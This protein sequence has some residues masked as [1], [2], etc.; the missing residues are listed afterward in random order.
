M[1][2]KARVTPTVEVAQSPFG[3]SPYVGHMAMRFGRGLRCVRCFCK[4]TDD[5]R[6]EE[7][8]CLD[9]Q[10]LQAIPCNMAYDLLCAGPLRGGAQAGIRA[11]HVVLIQWAKRR[12]G[13]L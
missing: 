9:G 5:Y 8:R 10:H 7:G 6:M 13:L 2:K 11:R 4:S 1:A 12:P 3:P